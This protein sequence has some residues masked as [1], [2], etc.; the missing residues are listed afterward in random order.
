MGKGRLLSKL[1]VGGAFAAAVASVFVPAGT[2][3]ILLPGAGLVA[4]AALVYGVHHYRLDRSLQWHVGRP[5]T[6]K[7]QG[8]GLALL[9]S[10]VIVRSM[11][12][13][14]ADLPSLADVFV[15]AAYPCMIAGVLL[16]VRGRAP[17][18]SVN[19]LLL[20]GII[21]SSTDGKRDSQFAD[22]TSPGL[23]TMF[24]GPGPTT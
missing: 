9:V 15:L 5:I 16:M 13:S 14:G 20:G 19:S 8:A 24:N 4:L 1:F 2:N 17:G 6:R 7:L 18:Q 11:V 12:G 21:A 22:D 10:S 3:K 23:L